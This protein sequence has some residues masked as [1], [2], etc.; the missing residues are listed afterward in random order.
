[1][2]APRAVTRSSHDSLPSLSSRTPCNK[3]GSCRRANASFG[4]PRVAVLACTCAIRRDGPRTSELTN[5]IV[6]LGCCR[7]SERRTSAEG[8]WVLPGEKG[9]RGVQE[10]KITR[11]SVRRERGTNGRGGGKV[12]GKKEREAEGGE[13]TFGLT[14]RMA[15][16]NERFYRYR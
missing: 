13:G 12:W 9:S 10:R 8:P 16:E 7:K 3:A 4:L 2:Q 5:S 11:T 6:F 15:R 1:M 14:N